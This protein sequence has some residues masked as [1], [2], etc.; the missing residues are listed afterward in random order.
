MR[1]IHET[2]LQVRENLRFYTNKPMCSSKGSFVS[3]GLVDIRP[4][5]IWIGSGCSFAVIIF[6]LEIISKVNLCK[7][8][9]ILQ[10][11]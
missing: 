10:K 6:L 7:I 8:S 2:G 11:K 1:R 4:A 9:E 3:V 5:L